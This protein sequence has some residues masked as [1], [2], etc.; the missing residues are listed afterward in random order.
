MTCCINSSY[1]MPTSAISD[2]ITEHEGHRN[3]GDVIIN[4][5]YIA[6]MSVL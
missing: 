6:R 5:I 4:L 1:N 3:K 2:I